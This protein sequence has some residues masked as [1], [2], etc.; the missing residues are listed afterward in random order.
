M[1]VC[2][3]QRERKRV[4]VCVC[5]YVYVCVLQCV[6]VCECMCV[7]VYVCVCVCECVY[8]SMCVYKCVCERE[9][10]GDKRKLESGGKI[11]W[12]QFPLIES[13]PPPFI[14]FVKQTLT[15]R[16]IDGLSSFADGK[17]FTVNIK[18]ACLMVTLTRV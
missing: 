6:C 11:P 7:W 5:V 4:C 9:R 3:S 14:F 10:E 2:V 12:V 17:K 15:K 13:F 16:S 8:V 1:C 18:H